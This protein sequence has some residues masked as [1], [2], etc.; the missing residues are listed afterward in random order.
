MSLNLWPTVTTSL[1][2]ALC[3]DSVQ[4]LYIAIMLM[5]FVIKAYFVRP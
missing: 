5:D 2:Y 1:L 4:S 3:I